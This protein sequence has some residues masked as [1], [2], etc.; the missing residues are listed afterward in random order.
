[1]SSPVITE[2][3]IACGVCQDECPEGAIWY[4]ESKEIFVIESER[5]KGHEVCKEV[6]PVYAIR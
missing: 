4:D 6:C 1:M 5:C 3:C 2:E